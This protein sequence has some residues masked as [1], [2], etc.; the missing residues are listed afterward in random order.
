MKEYAELNSLADEVANVATKIKVK[1]Y[2]AEYAL[3]KQ[4]VTE[5]LSA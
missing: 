3:A 4:Q 1:R 2:D 5:A